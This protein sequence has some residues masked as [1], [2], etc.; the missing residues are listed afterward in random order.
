VS[1]DNEEG[2]LDTRGKHNGGEGSPYQRARLAGVCK[3][4]TADGG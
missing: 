2:S 1:K 3:D 4:C